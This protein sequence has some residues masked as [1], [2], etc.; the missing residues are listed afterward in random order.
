[1][2]HLLHLSLLLALSSTTLHAHGR[3]LFSPS[4]GRILAIDS[5]TTP[6]AEVKLTPD[7]RFAITFLDADRKPIP[8]G[9]RK[10]VVTAGDRSASK[11]LSLE[12]QGETLITEPAPAGTDY[13]VIMQLREPGAAKSI[14]IRLHYDTALCSECKQ[15]E[16][17]CDC[18]SKTSGKNIP[19]PATLEGL[20]AEI[21]QHT[22]ELHQGTTDK[23]YEAI[24]EVTE[25]FPVLI[26][27]LPGK[28]NAAQ[29]PAATKLVT[30][31][32]TSLKAVRETFAARKPT[33]ATPHLQNITTTLTQLKALYPAEVA[34]AKL[35]DS[36]K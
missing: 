35:K 18:G 24:D 22:E 34:N 13:Y 20:W 25:A 29:Q 32:N 30:E 2:K 23:A 11:K 27:A 26:T 9:E 28:T 17:L 19:V 6:N 3:F 36:A 12:P 16:W 5:A 4:G 21:N 31:L 10:L 1:M 7:H 33:D 15:P 14:P 8:L